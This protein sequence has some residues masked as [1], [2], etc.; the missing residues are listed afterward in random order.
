MGAEMKQRH[1]NLNPTG[2]TV[3]KVTHPAVEAARQRFTLEPMKF[4]FPAEARKEA[5]AKYPKALAHNNAKD[6]ALREARR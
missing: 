6:W 5:R 4:L 2:R 3:Y 1:L